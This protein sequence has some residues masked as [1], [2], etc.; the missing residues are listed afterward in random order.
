VSAGFS[1]GRNGGGEF[2]SERDKKEEERECKR[3]K[4]A[5]KS[6]EEGKEGTRL[7]IGLLAALV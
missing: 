7:I 4:E 1:W 3:E 6:E 2:E 5:L